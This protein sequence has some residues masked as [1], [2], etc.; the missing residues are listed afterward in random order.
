MQAEVRYLPPHTRKGDILENLVG[1][2]PNAARATAP[3][4]IF[5]HTNLI[6]QFGVYEG[7][8]FFFNGGPR[9]IM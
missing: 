4:R 7:G 8:F 2:R 9:G 1:E 5:A 6:I 3:Q